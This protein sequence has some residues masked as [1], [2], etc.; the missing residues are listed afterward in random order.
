M[1]RRVAAACEGKRERQC[2]FPERG[3]VQWN[4]D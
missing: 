2:L 3:T 1:H 4:D